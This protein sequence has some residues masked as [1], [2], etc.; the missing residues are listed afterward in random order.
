MKVLITG[1][2][3]FIGSHTCVELLENNVE[4]VVMDNFCNSTPEAVEA[5]KSITGKDFS[6]L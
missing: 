4:I 5:I 1:G 3:G 6:F 2:A